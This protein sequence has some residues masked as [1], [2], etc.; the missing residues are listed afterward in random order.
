MHSPN[1]TVASPPSSSTISG[2]TSRQ[3]SAVSAT[4][5]GRAHAAPGLAITHGARVIDSTP[6]ATTTS[7]SPV[8]TSAA[9]DATAC[10]PLAHRRLTVKAGTSCGRPASRTAM[11]A[12]LRLSSPA[13]FAAPR[14]TWS[15]SAPATP[16][17]RSASP[18]AS[19]ARS[20]GRTNA[21]APP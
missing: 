11:R 1:V 3:P 6:P 4:S 8:A 18:T 7:A 2:F 9:A 15:T 13:W 16:V 12:T 21:S 14:I 20:S 19:A 17:R 5:P 10:N